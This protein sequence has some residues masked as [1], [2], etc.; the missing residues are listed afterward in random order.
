MLYEGLEKLE[1]VE[2]EE[3]P[4]CHKKEAVP[5][6]HLN[7]LSDAP[8]NEK[9]AGVWVPGSTALLESHRGITDQHPSKLA[10]AEAGS[11]IF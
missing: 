10:P 8:S 5:S 11:C 7:P 9:E 4:A 1:E 6:N 2:A 3:P